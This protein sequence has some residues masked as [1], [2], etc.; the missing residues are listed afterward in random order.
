MSYDVV[1]IGGGHAGC[2]AAAASARLGAKTLLVTHKKETIGEM[3][4]NPAF[5]GVAKGTLVKEIDALDGVMGRCIDKA[6]IHYKMLNESKGP[7]V[8]GPRAQADRKLYRKAMQEE[9]FNYLNLEILEGS[10][11]NIIIED[12]RVSRLS[13]LVAGKA[14]NEQLVTNN[15]VLT[16]GTFLRGLMH[17]GEEKTAGG[18]VGEAPALGISDALEKAG[19]TLGR[20]KTGTPARLDAKTIDFGSLEKQHGDNPPK[21]FSW[22]TEAVN[23]PQIPCHITYTSPLTHQI[24]AANI[25]RSPMYSG[26]IQST[27][28]RYCPSIEDKIMRFAD[29]ERHQIF[30]EPEGLDD[31]T[32]YPNGDRKSVV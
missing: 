29:K 12:G 7:A 18:R 14:S 10:V 5:G 11:D 19:L 16:T 17:T 32:I 21:P 8:W 30:L 26:Q 3:S 4:C 6:G 28:P 13:L 23:V 25:H 20:L 1:V 9:L 2:E 22:L 24:I 31:D 27:G 15:V